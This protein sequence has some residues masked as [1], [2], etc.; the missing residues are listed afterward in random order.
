MTNKVQR[1]FVAGWMMGFIAVGGSGYAEAL[2]VPE[3]PVVLTVSGNIGKTNG[4][5]L[6][7]F[8]LG[9]LEA[10][11]A[12]TFETTTIW[13]EG[14]REFSGVSLHTFLSAVGAKGQVLSAVAIDNYS[15]EIPADEIAPDGPIIAYR[16]DG[17]TMSVRDKGP[18]WVVYPFDSDPKYQ[19]GVAHSRSIWQLVS[20]DV[21]DE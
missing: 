19:S 9:M 20:I 13:T 3:G 8:D 15:V 16:M 14:V 18:L 12:T 10:L 11:P 7:R 6:A 5:G 17:Q 21:S 2:A 4:D 1:F